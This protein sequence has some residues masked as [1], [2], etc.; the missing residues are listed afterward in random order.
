MS[1]FIDP[2]G[3]KITVVAV[4]P[5]ADE[6][7]YDFEVI[8]KTIKS[9]RAWQTDAVSSYKEIEPVSADQN[10]ILKPK[11]VTTVVLEI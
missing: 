5:N 10:I 2:S 9:I 6:A 1:A 8:G 3:K 11:S 7:W 4:N